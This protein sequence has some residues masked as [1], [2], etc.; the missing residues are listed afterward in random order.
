MTLGGG[1]GR[2][3]VQTNQSSLVA[4]LGVT[5]NRE[6]PVEGEGR[7]SAE[8][9]LAGQYSTFMYDFPKLK[10]SASLK[11][12]PSLTDLGRVRLQ[13]DAS[14]QREIVSD[15]YVAIRIFD[16]FDSRPP[17]QGSAKNDWGP[18]VSIGYKF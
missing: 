8:A 9:I 3:L 17:T 5:G 12:I 16:S 18:V 13:A 14:A 7:Y 15:F 10:V 1:F 6:V 2:Y 4:L 11:V